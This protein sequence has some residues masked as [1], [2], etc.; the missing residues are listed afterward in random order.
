MAKVIEFYV[1]SSYKKKTRWLPDSLRGKIIDFP[2]ELKKP[3]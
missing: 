1:P 3:A 2:G